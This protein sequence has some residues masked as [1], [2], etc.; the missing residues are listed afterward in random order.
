M[1]FEYTTRQG[2]TVDYIAWR[3]Y[4]RQDNQVVEGLLEANQGLADRGPSLP[5]GITI[6]L[7]DMPEPEQ[8]NGVRLWD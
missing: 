8:E 6:T 1:A 3:H 2:D 7:P 4:G 5:A